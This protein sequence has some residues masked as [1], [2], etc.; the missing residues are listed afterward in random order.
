MPHTQTVYR[1][2]IHTL[3]KVFGLHFRFFLCRGK[4]ECRLSRLNGT[5]FAVCIEHTSATFRLYRSRIQF[6][7]RF[8]THQMC[9]TY[10]LYSISLSMIPRVLRGN[11]TL[12]VAAARMRVWTCRSSSICFIKFCKFHHLECHSIGS[13]K[14]EVW[15]RPLY[16]ADAQ[17]SLTA[18][19]SM[20]VG[21]F[22]RSQH[23]ERIWVRFFTV[24]FGI[25][26]VRISSFENLAVSWRD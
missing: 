7:G 9:F 13:L 23:P 18:G 11:L 22:H 12:L 24:G 26:N 21:I 14:S 19:T 8:A 20:L 25:L 3:G 15:S 2:F 16:V 4:Y 10:V 6:G 17:Q 5:Y 1:R